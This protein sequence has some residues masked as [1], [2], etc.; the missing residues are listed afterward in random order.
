[1]SKLLSVSV[2][3]YNVQE[4][5]QQAL[6]SFLDSEILPLVQVIVVD[7]GSHDDT[8]AIAQQYV[9]AHPETFVLVQKIN[10]GYGSTINASLDL[11]CGTY[12]RVLDGDDWFDTKE[13]KKLLS[14][15]DTARE[16]VVLCNAYRKVYENG[17]EKVVNLPIAASQN[18]DFSSLDAVTVIEHHLT[19]FKTQCLLRQG[20]QPLLEHCFYTDEQYMLQGLLK[21]EKIAVVDC[22]PYCYRL[23]LVGQSVSVQGYAAHYLDGIRCN[24]ALQD[25][26]RPYLGE[27]L[28]PK[29]TFLVRFVANS[30]QNLYGM[31][32][33]LP[34]NRENKKKLL[35]YHRY[36]QTENPTVYVHA[37]AKKI[38]FLR[39]SRFLLYRPMA[40]A[41]KRKL[42]RDNHI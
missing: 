16:D 6:D 20:W 26:I 37:H 30:V 19:V 38:V 32:L 18:L 7:D 36:M 4:T 23:G 31:F 12:F 3:A 27:T 8:A 13:L 2:A 40:W 41:W 33:C 22:C 9:Q 17:G 11:A 21:A 29:V 34:A 39:C 24:Q 1:M 14:F 10:G 28:T 42:R 25:M 5:L 15:L 35:A